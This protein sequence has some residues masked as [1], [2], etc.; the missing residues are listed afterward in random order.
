[1]TVKKTVQSQ[2]IRPSTGSIRSQYAFLLTGVATIV[3][4][5]VAWQAVSSIDSLGRSAL[6]IGKMAAVDQ[7]VMDEIRDAMNQNLRSF[8]FGRVVPFSI[9]ILGVTFVIGMIWTNRIVNPLKQ[10]VE[11][12]RIIQKEGLSSTVKGTVAVEDIP[13]YPNEAPGEI[14]LL[15]KEL[16]DM[17]EHLRLRQVIL[18]N[19]SAEQSHIL[20]KRTDQLLAAAHLAREAT[21]THQS[22]HLMDRS[23]NLIGD[24]F[25]Y[26]HVAIFLIDPSGQYAVLRAASGGAGQKMLA[27]GHH[28]KVGDGIE[29]HDG[30]GHRQASIVGYVAST[31]LVR[32]VPDVEVDTTYFRNPLLPETRAEIALPLRVSQRMVG[33]LDVQCQVPGGFAEEDVL[34]LQ[35][36]ADQ[37]SVAIDKAHWFQ[38]YQETLAKL[39]LVRREE[40]PSGRRYQLP[41]RKIDGFI[42]DLTGVKPILSGNEA[43]LIE[44]KPSGTPLHVPLTVRGE[45]V[46]TLD[47]WSERDTLSV[48]EMNLLNEIRLRLSQAIESAQLF[49]ET[50]VRGRREQ[51]MN[52]FVTNLSRSLDLDALLQQSVRELAQMPNVN[53]VSIVIKPAT[54]EGTAAAVTGDGKEHRTTG[55]D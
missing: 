35:T 13:A 19:H 36:L 44:E 45:V 10:L 50:Q 54:V 51:I 5:V 31:G 4:L 14:G 49:E 1:M 43:N 17:V 42:Y 20:E 38:Q 33:V 46:A 6:D 55:F 2:D 37:I 48:Q 7:A 30:R 3:V 32:A 12:A 28:L 22:E 25:G 26:Y 41:I 29:H 34:V 11:N 47:L 27:M 15:A 23:V 40:Q 9:L 21:I 8:V 16:M 18:E 24:R 39:D 52:Q 53:E